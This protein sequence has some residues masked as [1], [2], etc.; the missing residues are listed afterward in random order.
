MAQQMQANLKQ[1]QNEKRRF[2]VSERSVNSSQMF[3][4]VLKDD[5]MISPLEHSII[6][7]VRDALVSTNVA[8]QMFDIIFYLKTTPQLCKQRLSVRNRKEETT[9]TLE[10][11]QKLHDKYEQ[12]LNVRF[13]PNIARNVVV[14]NGFDT[15]DDIA[16]QAAYIL[17]IANSV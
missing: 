9:I 13:A 15:V 10:Y 8:L 2:F 3:V 6:D 12:K 4:D 11:L 16:K 17:T 1:A 14:L 5:G 7:N